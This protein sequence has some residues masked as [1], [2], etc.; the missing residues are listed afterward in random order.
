MKGLS[1]K[2]TLHQAKCV[3]DFASGDSNV[4]VPKKIS[5]SG[6]CYADVKKKKKKKNYANI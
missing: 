6:N 2:E 5:L 3:L 1:Q 4:K